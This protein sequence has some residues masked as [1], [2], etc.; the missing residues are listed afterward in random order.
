MKRTVEEL[1]HGGERNGG[2]LGRSAI[3]ELQIG[4]GRERNN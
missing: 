3:E 2:S 1:S 4:E